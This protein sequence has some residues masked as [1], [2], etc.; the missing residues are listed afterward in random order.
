[1]TDTL[2]QINYYGWL[3]DGVIQYLLAPA[4]YHLRKTVSFIQQGGIDNLV[5][6]FGE[7]G[8]AIKVIPKEVKECKEVYD[9]VK[10]LEKIAEEFEELIILNQI[11]SN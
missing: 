9:I 2:F 11:Y 1:M 4:F 7:I 8:E 3:R 10:S 6:G 5:K